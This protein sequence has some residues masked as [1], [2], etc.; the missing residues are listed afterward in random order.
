MDFSLC[1]IGC[2][3]RSERWGCIVSFLANIFFSDSW[4]FSLQQQCC[5]VILPVFTS[6]EVDDRLALVVNQLVV[7]FLVRV[8]RISRFL[9]QLWTS[10]FKRQHLQLFFLSKSEE[11]AD[12][13]GSYLTSWRTALLQK[14]KNQI[15]SFHFSSI[16]QRFASQRNLIFPSQWDGIWCDFIATWN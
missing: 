11:I 13:A 14:T 5:L 3:R 4:Q 12:W 7:V 8:R 2:S 1:F 9:H 16:L 10:T 6:P 15:E